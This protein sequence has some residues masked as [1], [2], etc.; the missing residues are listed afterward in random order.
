M[1]HIETTDQKSD[2][3][4]QTPYQH[5]QTAPSEHAPSELPAP[6][7]S[8]RCDGVVGLPALSSNDED[9][10]SHTSRTGRYVTDEANA[11]DLARRGLLYDHGAQKLAGGMHYYTMS[12]DGRA[13]LNAHRQSARPIPRQPQPNDRRSDT[14]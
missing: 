13:A 12:P 6:Q 4:R 9:I 10:L 1:H 8:L 5:D 7:G 3:H 2:L 11:A 14:P